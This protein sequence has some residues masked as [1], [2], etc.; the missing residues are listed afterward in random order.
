MEVVGREGVRIRGDERVGIW[1]REMRWEAKTGG[2]ASRKMGRD[3]PSSAELACHRDPLPL[4]LR[5][6][7]SSVG[8][9][10]ALKGHGIDFGKLVGSQYRRGV[11]DGG[12]HC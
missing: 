7:L 6:Y 9:R 8:G 3:L 11:W 4:V 2:D 10:V 1:G 12:L 5:I